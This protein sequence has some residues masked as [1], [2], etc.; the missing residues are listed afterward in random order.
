[1]K[2]R[3]LTLLKKHLIICCAMSGVALLFACASST[4]QS[5][6]STQATENTLLL[7]KIQKISNL[8]KIDLNAIQKE[9]SFTVN[10]EKSRIRKA[11]SF[12]IFD[13]DENKYEYSD[14]K[15]EGANDYY[16]D[17]GLDIEKRCIVK[18]DIVAIF[19]NNFV[20]HPSLINVPYGLEYP[21]VKDMLYRTKHHELDFFIGHTAN[22]CLHHVVVHNY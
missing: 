4:E 6:S 21:K 3:Q 10:K 20:T 11:N 12:Y 8:E 19:G 9:F 16:F 22:N 5:P 2:Y 15:L 14:F 13:V 1:M 7:Q 17:V 18:K